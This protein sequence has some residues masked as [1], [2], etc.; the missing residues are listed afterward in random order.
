MMASELPR[1]AAPVLRTSGLEKNYGE[2]DGR[3]RAL[4]GVEL[5]VAS[6]ETLAVMG[7]SGCGSTPPGTSAGARPGPRFCCWP[8]RPRP[9]RA[10]T[11]P[12]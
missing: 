10:S 8:S 9:P 2:G 12:P 11:K 6:G 3:V 4:V 1:D 5:E 7:P